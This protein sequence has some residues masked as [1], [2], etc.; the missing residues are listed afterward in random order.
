VENLKLID[1]RMVGFASLWIFGLALIL[2][3]LGLADYLVAV[4]G[5]RTRD[6]LR[7]PS[8][9]NAIN[10]GLT[11]FSLGLIGSSN[12]WWEIVLWGLLAVSFAYFTWKGWRARRSQLNVADPS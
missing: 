9:Q 1:W 12:A 2:S 3:A 7:E 5:G 10:V 4:E 8:Y 11:L 6:R